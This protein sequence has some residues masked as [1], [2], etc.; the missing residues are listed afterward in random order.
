MREAKRSLHISMEVE[1]NECYTPQLEDVKNKKI[2][3]DDNLNHRPR[4]YD[5]PALTP[6]YTEIPS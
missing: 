5:S 4:D 1:I 3:Q 2:Y 6:K